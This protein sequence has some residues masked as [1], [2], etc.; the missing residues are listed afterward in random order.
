MRLAL[1]TTLLVACTAG[2]GGFPINTDTDTD[3]MVAGPSYAP[4]AGSFVL[5]ELLV[6]GQA[7]AIDLASTSVCK[8]SDGNGAAWNIEAQGAPYATIVAELT[9]PGPQDLDQSFVANLHG[10]SPS[11]LRFT[12]A[13]FF[14]GTWVANTLTPIGISFQGQA[15]TTTGNMLNLNFTATAD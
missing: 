2:G 10:A 12:G 5:N 6:N 14:Q 3:C 13:D 8:R 15:T 9:A 4:A 11:A 7:V 1:L